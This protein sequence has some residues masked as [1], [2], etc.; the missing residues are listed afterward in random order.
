MTDPCLEFEVIRLLRHRWELHGTLYFEFQPGVFAGQHWQPGSVY[1]YEEFWADLGAIVARHVPGYSHYAFTSVSAESWVCILGEFDVL[2]SGL[3][4]A[5]HRPDAA[6]RLP[7]LFRWFEPLEG[8]YW[9]RYVLQYATLVRELSEWV[10]SQLAEHGT[11][12]V[13][14]I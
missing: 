1:V 10:R 5:K 3:R 6:I 7:S 8:R 11:V 13:L 12:S 4:A 9:R 14:G 2:T